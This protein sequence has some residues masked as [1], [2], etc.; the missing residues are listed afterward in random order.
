MRV[1][2]SR[3]SSGRSGISTGAGRKIS[4]CM[5]AKSLACILCKGNDESKGTEVGRGVEHFR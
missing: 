3:I 4:I 1:G 5:D 2:G